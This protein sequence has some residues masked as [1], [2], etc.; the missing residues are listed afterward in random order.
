MSTLT[1]LPSGPVPLIAARSKPFSAAIALATGLTNIRVDDGTTGV[2]KAGGAMPGAA[3]FTAG[4][5][6]VAVAGEEAILVRE[7]EANLSTSSLFS[8][9]TQIGYEIG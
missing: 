3:L 2:L 8:A 9:K 4:A 6:G 1:I 5:D 7:N